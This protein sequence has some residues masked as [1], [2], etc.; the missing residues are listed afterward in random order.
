MAPQTKA[1]ART[2]ALWGGFALAELIFTAATVV[3]A[4]A[5]LTQ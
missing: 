3:L 5:W 2:V 1:R 4:V